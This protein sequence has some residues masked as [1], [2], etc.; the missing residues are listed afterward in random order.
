ML[1]YNN[2]IH[3]LF[4]QNPKGVDLLDIWRRQFVMA[5]IVIPGNS[6]EAH[7]IREGSA[8]FVRNIIET[9]ELVEHN[10]NLPENSDA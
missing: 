4:K 8:K 2:L 5:P 1:N 7:G 3:E 6:P 10:Y 9:I